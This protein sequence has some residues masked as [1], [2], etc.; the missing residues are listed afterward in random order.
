MMWGD[1]PPVGHKISLQASKENPLQNLLG[2]HQYWV[3]SGTSALAL[4][5]CDVREQFAHV[6]YPRVIIPGYCCPDLV[7]AC[8]FAGVEAVAIDISVDDPSYDFDQLRTHLDGNVIAVVAVNFLGIAERLM[9]LR[10]LITELGLNTRIIEDNAQWFPSS[11]KEA[12]FSSDYV[13]FS[14]GRGKPL[15]LLG[16]GLLLSA[17]PL[18]SSLVRKIA[19]AES[20][21]RLLPWKI[22]AYNVL[23]KPQFYLLLNRNPLLS[24]GK[25]EYHP[26]NE[27]RF[28]DGFR[29]DLLLENFNAYRKREST[30]ADA[31]H[32]QV[33]DSGLQSLAALNSSRARRLLRYPLLCGS[34]EQRDAL[35]K[36]CNNAGLGSTAMYANALDKVNGVAGRVTVPAAL[37]NATHFARRFMTLPVH[38]GVTKYHQ[39]KMKQILQ[40]AGN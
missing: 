10:R 8:V 30:V 38:T 15:S 23:L 17:T 37:D 5:L 20:P 11:D 12:I 4:A 33:T 1:L 28:M 13:T 39:A 21:S 35:L 6:Q 24:L 14:F 18:D 40:M 25:T 29:C 31:I 19:P 34:V 16:G 27:V 3:D 7:A 9:E 2:M 32:S 22:R 26:L 36:S